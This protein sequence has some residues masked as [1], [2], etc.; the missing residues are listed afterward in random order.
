[1]QRSR[2]R[3][4]IYSSA[5]LLAVG[6]G[7]GAAFAATD[8][9]TGSLTASFAKDS[10]WGTG[11]QAHYTIK[12][13]T[14]APVNGW[15]L[16]FGLPSTAKLGSVWDAAV[17]TSGNV[18]TVT[19]A[20]W[21]PTIPA[22]GEISFGFV[23]A[24]KGDPAS[25]TI[26][27]A[28]CTAGGATAAPTVTATA[29][30][31]ATAKPTATP[32]RTATSPAPTR[33]AT[34]TPTAT[35]GTGS[36]SG[37]LVA[38]YV[39]MG[40]LSNGGTLSALAGGGNVKSF[41]LAFV[42]ASG[43]KASWFGAFDPRARQFADQIGAIRSAGG[44]VKV[45]FGGATGV[46]LAQACTST[47]ALQAEYQAVVDAYDLKYI[48]LD[49]E[50]AA[51]A[52]T[53]SINRRSTALAGL[54]KANPG[55]KISLTLPVLPEGL[56][57]DGLNVVKSAKNAGVDLDLVNIMAM[58]YGRSGQDYGDLAIQAVKSTKD[59]IRSIYGNSDAAAFK[60]V[61]VTPMIGKNDD[62]GTFSQ[63]DAR[64]LVAFANANHVGF[65]SF[66]EMQRD[67]NACQGALFQCTNIS[68]T[69]FEFSK[70]FAGFK[71]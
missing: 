42:T 66:W 13:G 70:I 54:Q 8:G 23:V 25:C 43:C 49:I 67:K 68:Q 62:S 71:G 31:T 58:D 29:T 46:E 36:A 18:E 32:T 5:A 47:S 59:Q 69:A 12:N 7:I 60:M 63:S 27:G 56:T 4:A 15:Q 3:L 1:M 57:A 9:G 45:S 55:L 34:A 16:V 30:A 50:G 35:G 21:N 44:D 11:Y 20:A 14:D 17:T 37:V 2:M 53:A 22:G 26:N 28:S 65:V 38:P 61:G 39:D 19:N 52:D 24:G 48:D 33:T 64:D 41:S 10:D 6:G 51:S 40:V